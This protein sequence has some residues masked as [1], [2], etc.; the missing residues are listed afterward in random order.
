MART[1]MS[2]LV[3]VGG[4]F[5]PTMFDERALFNGELEPDQL[6]AG[7]I[8]RF[9]YSSGVS[10][11]NVTPERIDLECLSTVIVPQPVVDAARI[12]AGVIEPARG[13][14]RVL[15]SAPLVHSHPMSPRT[16]A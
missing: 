5:P 6:K 10:R 16:P 15:S 12:L 4:E 14:V 2:S 7:P 3:F 13:A 9:S 1:Y 11:F 8:G